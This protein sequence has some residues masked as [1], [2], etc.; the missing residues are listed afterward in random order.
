MKDDPNCLRFAPEGWHTITPRIVVDG[1]SQFVEFLWQVFGAR[2]E[3]L[4]ARPSVLRIGD[5]LV[6]I[7]DAGIRN[8]MTAFLYIYV[9]DADATYQRALNAG[10]RSLEEPFNTPYGDRRCMV[11]DKWGNTWQIATQMADIA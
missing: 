3:Y 9:N 10:A 4:E 7:S 5:S 1:A 2:G 6:M 8:P 11:E